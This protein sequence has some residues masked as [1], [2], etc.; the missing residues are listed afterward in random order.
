MHSFN[1][2]VHNI[3]HNGGYDGDFILTIDPDGKT[4]SGEYF[5]ETDVGIDKKPYMSIRINGDDLRDFLAQIIRHKMVA[6]WEDKPT[7]EILGI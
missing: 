7:E 3:H 1:G 4:A 5:V 6:E 2:K